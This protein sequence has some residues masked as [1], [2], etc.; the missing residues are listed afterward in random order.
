MSS[1]STRLPPADA[2]RF[3]ARTR[4][5]LLLHA[6]TRSPPDKDNNPDIQT[7]QPARAR[8]VYGTNQITTHFRHR[9]PNHVAHNAAPQ[10]TL[11]NGMSLTGPAM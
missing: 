10:S 1:A 8:S 11:C 7:L 9:E 2:R 3:L 4:P 5:A 6:V